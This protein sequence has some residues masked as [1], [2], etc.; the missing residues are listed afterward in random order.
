VNKL[1][2]GWDVKTIYTIV[3]LRASVSEILTVQTIGRGLRLPF[4]RQV[5]RD[6]GLS[7]AERQELL[8]IDTLDI[9]SHEK[10]SAVLNKVK[11]E[12]DWDVGV[13]PVSEEE[14]ESREVIPDG[15]KEYQLSI[16]VIESK[17]HTETELDLS[18]IKPNFENLQDL[19]VKLVGTDLGSLEERDY[20]RIL[21]ECQGSLVNFFVRILIEETDDFDILDKERLQRFVKAY[22][23]KAQVDS[24]IRKEVLFKHRGKIARDL[25]DQIRKRTDEKTEIKY[26]ATKKMV[27]FRP[28]RRNVPKG[29]KEKSKVAVLDKE[30]VHRIISGYAK[31]FF[32]RNVFDSKPEKLLADVLDQD[33]DVFRWVRPPGGQLTIGYKGGTYNPDFVVETKGHL[34]YLVEVKAA[35]ELNAN[36]TLAKARAGKGWCLAMSKATGKTWEYKLIPD[37]AVNPSASFK[38]VISNAVEIT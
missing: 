7:E 33:K 28:Y 11:A 4:G 29:L 38:G 36:D 18:G 27:E 31:S 34:F 10:Y 32:S 8:E 6:P 35:N 2:E 14:W 15:P 21:E 25:I 24:G 5:S 1:K 17:F 26:V 20:D 3:P 23:D 12:P 37:T 16:P 9:V 30:L 13:A 22:L 19:E